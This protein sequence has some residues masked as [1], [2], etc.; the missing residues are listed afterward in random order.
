ME[1]LRP[2]M[3]L[4]R[5]AVLPRPPVGCPVQRHAAR[6]AAAAPAAAL[7]QQQ[8]RQRVTAAAAAA[9]G[10]RSRPLGLRTPLPQRRAPPQTRRVAASVAAES[11]LDREKGRS[12][13]RTVFY[14]QEWRNHRSIT[15]YFR[16]MDGILTSRIVRG[17][18]PPLV[19][20]LL[21]SYLVCV[22][23]TLWLE[24]TLDSLVPWM[25]WPDVAVSPEGPFSISTFALSLLLVFR[26]NSS[27]DRWCEAST[28][29]N[30]VVASVGHLARQS[31]Q[32]LPSDAPEDERIRA[33]LLRW[34]RAFPVT[35]MCNVREEEEQMPV[36]LQGVLLPEELALVLRSPLPP[37]TALMMIGSLISSSN[38]SI[39]SKTHMDESVRIMQDAFEVCEKIV[40]TPLPLSYSRH[41]SRF[42][43][44]WLTFLPFCAWS[45]LGWATVPVDVILG[46]FL[47]GIEEI[48]VQVEEPCGLL[49]LEHW[50]TVIDDRITQISN[51]HHEV[52]AVQRLCLTAG[53]ASGAAN[54]HAA[55]EAAAARVPSPEAPPSPRQTVS[56][57]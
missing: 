1:A 16:H 29:W 22:Y 27:Y 42:L 5:G 54:G 10:T 26:T 51:E 36:L 33:G 8:R 37:Q 46:F 2:P 43:V 47:L 31:C 30:S 53:V 15:R 19:C 17:L 40:R 3:L 20:V 12:Y 52:L 18:L 6:A 56:S 44:A 38:M 32:W 21:S 14:Q 11:D 7:G 49:A 48:G 23:E 50:C 34:L 39:E 4:R 57:R 13:R 55:A 45:E 41:T 35:L 24:G 25:P 28:A 9:Q